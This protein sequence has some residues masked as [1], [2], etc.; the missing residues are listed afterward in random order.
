[1]LDIRLIREKPDFVRERLATRGGDDEMKIDEVLR[2]DGQRRKLE[3]SLQQLNADR[4]RLSKEIGAKRSSGGATAELE[5]RVQEIGE[6]IVDLNKRTAAAEVEQEGLLLEIAN[7]PHE[8]VPIGKDPSANRLVRSWGEKPRLTE[9]ADHV[10][11]GAKLKLFDLERAAKLSGSGFI[12]FTGAGAKLE[13]AL[14]N[15]MLDLHTREHGYFEIS[16]PFLVRRDCMIG[17]GQLP[18]FESDMYGLENGELFLAPTAEVPVTNLYRGEILNFVDLPKKFVAYTPCFRRE[19]GAAG[20]ETRGIIRVHQFDKVELVKITTPERSYDELESLTADAERALQLLG[21]HYRILE[22]CTGDLGFHAAK[23]YDIEV[24]SPG[25]NGY[26]EVS[27]CSNFEEFQARRMNLRYKGVDGQNHFCH[28][29]NGS[30]LALPRLFAALVES[31][32]QADGS[33]RIP[34]KLRAYFAGTEIRL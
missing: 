33:I 7:L 2:V 15:F 9:P 26:L 32:Q 8:S 5:A 20:R 3:T 12:C 30:G 21:L 31:C 1:M 17:T 19:A 24:W 28:T 25:Q 27:S 6:A 34:E 14:I 4:R 22:L 11:L 29:L 10:A 16:P 23:T 13:R 18:K